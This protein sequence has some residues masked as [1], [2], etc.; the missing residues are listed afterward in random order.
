MPALRFE[1]AAFF[2][3]ALVARHDIFINGTAHTIPE[4]VRAYAKIAFIETKV[5]SHGC[6]VICLNNVV[7]KFSRFD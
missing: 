2:R 5:T 1:S 6:V 7:L 4:K 3:L